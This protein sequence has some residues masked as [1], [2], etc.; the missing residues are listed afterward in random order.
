[1]K[2]TK[3]N[4][5]TLKNAIETLETINERI[6]SA[7]D[8]LAMDSGVPE[9]A[10]EE[11]LKEA[12]WARS[13]EEIYE[14]IETALEMLDQAATH[15]DMIRGILDEESYEGVDSDRD[16]DDNE[17]NICDKCS[18]RMNRKGRRR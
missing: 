6:L 2:G 14:T 3:V 18:R 9:C 5:R 15:A 12:I 4:K 10:S 17:P 11:Q 16:F 1:L 13:P 8:L 7:Y